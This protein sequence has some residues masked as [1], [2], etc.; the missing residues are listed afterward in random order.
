MKMLVHANATNVEEAVQAVSHDVISLYIFICIYASMYIL[1]FG[2]VC[3]YVLCQYKNEDIF[4]FTIQ[5]TLVLESSREGDMKG[6]RDALSRGANVNIGN[7]VCQLVI[8]TQ[9]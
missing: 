7:N 9:L 8:C 6:I 4:T 2:R 1:L 3:I 5:D